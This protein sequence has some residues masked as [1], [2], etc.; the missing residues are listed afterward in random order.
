MQRQFTPTVQGLLDSSAM[1]CATK[2]GILKLA[3][4]GMADLR[5]AGNS[6]QEPDLRGGWIARV[7]KSFGELGRESATGCHRAISMAR[8]RRRGVAPVL[9]GANCL[10][11][12]RGIPRPSP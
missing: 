7:F 1:E 4:Y 10:R 8:K 11:S 6:S 9:Q 3:P 12:R 2:V 5:Q